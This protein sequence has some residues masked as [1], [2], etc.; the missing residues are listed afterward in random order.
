MDMS[1]WVLFIF[2]RATAA[3]DGFCVP[4]LIQAS[5]E[6]TTPTLVNGEEFEGLL[7]IASKVFE[8]KH[9]AEKIGVRTRL[10]HLPSVGQEVAFGTPVATGKNRKN[11]FD[12]R[13]YKTRENNGRELW[14]NFTEFSEVLGRLGQLL[15]HLQSTARD[16]GKL[17]RWDNKEDLIQFLKLMRQ[18][19]EGRLEEMQTRLVAQNEAELRWSRKNPQPSL[20]TP[21][22]KKLIRE[23][24]AHCFSSTYR[25]RDWF[26]Y[27]SVKWLRFLSAASATGFLGVGAATYEHFLALA[28]VGVGSVISL[29]S[30]VFASDLDSFWPLSKFIYLINPDV[31]PRFHFFLDWLLKRYEEN[32]AFEKEDAFYFSFNNGNH[33]DI[34][35]FPAKNLMY[36]Y[37][38]K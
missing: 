16:S 9:A 24:S 12:L 21:L 30:L 22:P 38:W 2:L 13:V 3:P 35:I 15:G 28:G 19:F 18:R 14:L 8:A 26:G 37:V 4:S 5:L 17:F 36:L 10:A 6:R 27:S 33:I 7:K 23:L 31:V 32:Y 29:G 20:E 34:L 1:I 11:L 25:Q